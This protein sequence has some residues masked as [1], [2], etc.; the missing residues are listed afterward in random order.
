MNKQEAVTVYAPIDPERL[1]RLKEVLKHIR[2]DVE[3]N[4]LFPFQEIQFLHFSRFIILNE[5]KDLEGEVIPAQLVFM[6]NVDIPPKQFLEHLLNQ[7]NSGVDAV[8]ECCCNYP[9]Q[10]QRSDK[11]RLEFLTSHLIPYNGFYVN[12]IGRP[13]SQIRQ[14][15]KLHQAIEQFLNQKNW[16]TE[17]APEIRTA[18]QDFVFHEP[19]LDW[20]KSPAKPL[21]LWWRLKE[22]IRLISLATLLFLAGLVFWP[23]IVI[24][25]L[26]LRLREQEDPVDKIRPSTERL[27]T[28]R[29]FE[30][31]FAHNQFSA[32]GFVKPGR[33]RRITIRVVLALAQI[34][35]R[36]I[37]NKGDLATIKL[38]GLNGVDTI[39]FARWVAVDN[40]RR[41]I[42]ASN[43]DGSLESYMGDFID[44]VAWGLNI[45]FTNG[46][47][48]PRTRWIIHEGAEDELAFKNYLRNHQVFTEVWYSPYPQLTAVNISNNAAIR[49]GLY[50]E[51]DEHEVQAWLQKL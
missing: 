25:I 10:G 9:E 23:I 44:K 20:A 51:M 15:A 12:T 29:S 30:D 34:S 21:P 33:L 8:F 26:M 45:V 2:H 16:S 18:I 42:F 27:N 32:V 46:R 50:G 31:T 40:N 39:H 28:L 36:H 47:G 5:V 1:P 43:Y 22:K 3:K 41:L 14:E 49:A 38:L 13:V 4:D 6:A 7:I 17:N 19:S 37:F 24:W 11:T 48:Y 35:F